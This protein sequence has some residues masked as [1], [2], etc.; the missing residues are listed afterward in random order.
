MTKKE[1]LAEFREYILPFIPK[2]DI[3]AKCEAWNDFTD[4]LC[5][6]RR[7]TSKQYDTWVNPF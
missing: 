5:K 3:P 2:G 4:G 6:D 7:I 1:A